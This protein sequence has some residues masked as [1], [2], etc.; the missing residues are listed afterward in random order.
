MFVPQ[1]TDNRVAY[2]RDIHTP[3]HQTNAI[4][5]TKVCVAKQSHLF[6]S[7]LPI[8]SGSRVCFVLY[9]TVYIYIAS[10]I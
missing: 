3:T 8:Y 1:T 10:F 7:Q 2:S 4:H 9:T 6:V 5:K